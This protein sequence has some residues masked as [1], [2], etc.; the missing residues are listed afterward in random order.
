MPPKRCP[1][2]GRKLAR[3]KTCKYICKNK[4]CPVIYVK[5]DRE[6]QIKRIVKASVLT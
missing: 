3:T 2:C 4:L 1:V 6:G 5:Y